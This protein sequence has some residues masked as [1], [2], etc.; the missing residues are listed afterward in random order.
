[1]FLILMMTAVTS[2]MV[3]SCFFVPQNQEAKSTET[4]FGYFQ[5]LPPSISE[6][7]KEIQKQQDDLWEQHRYSELKS[8]T[9]EE[10]DLVARCIY[11]EAR[12]EE[13]DGQIAVCEVVF[14]RILS[15]AYPNTVEDVLFQYNGSFYQFS[16]APYLN[17]DNIK[18]PLSM[19]KAKEIVDY[20]LSTEYSPIIPADYL[21]FSTNKPKAENYLKIGNHYF[22]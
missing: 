16:C 6:I 17:T 21:Y 20:V 15:D 13:P 11:H 18:E 3:C 10:R 2:T 22:R 12:G 8:L 4:D 7:D 1:M 9:V 14:N 19:E 5:E